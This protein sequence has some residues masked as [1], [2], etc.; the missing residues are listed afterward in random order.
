M[1]HVWFLEHT[2]VLP[3]FEPLSLAME[4]FRREPC[5][6]GDGSVPGEIPAVTLTTLVLASWQVALGLRQTRTPAATPPCLKPHSN[7]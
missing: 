5:E 4:G 1:D 2:W 3:I 6:V 7:P